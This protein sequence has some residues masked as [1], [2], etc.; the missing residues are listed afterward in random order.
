[1]NLGGLD[2]KLGIKFT[3]GHTSV[4]RYQS[5]LQYHHNMQI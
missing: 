4:N 2:C 1:M 5:Y 3:L